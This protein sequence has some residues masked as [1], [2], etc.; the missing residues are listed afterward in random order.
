MKIQRPKPVAEGNTAILS[1]GNCLPP[2]AAHRDWCGPKYAR[3]G[4]ADLK[5]AQKYFRVAPP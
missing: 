2:A 3:S 1:P 4:S 5:D